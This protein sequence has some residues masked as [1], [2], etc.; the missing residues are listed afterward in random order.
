MI[1]GTK[2][3]PA[4]I[5]GTNEST[6]IKN[7]LTKTWSTLANFKNKTDVNKTNI[8]FEIS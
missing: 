1:A 6:V 7:D 2:Y 5:I 3:T 8:I 4:P